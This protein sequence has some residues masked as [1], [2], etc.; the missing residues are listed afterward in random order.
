MGSKR[1]RD[2][3]DTFGSTHLSLPLK[4]PHMNLSYGRSLGIQ[5]PSYLCLSWSTCFACLLR[6]LQWI[7]SRSW[8]QHQKTIIRGPQTPKVRCPPCP[9][10]RRFN[11]SV[12]RTLP[13]APN[14]TC[15]TRS[16]STNSSLSTLHSLQVRHVWMMLHVPFSMRASISLLCSRMH[17][18]GL[19][20]Q[21][22]TCMDVFCKWDHFVDGAIHDD[23]AW[24][25]S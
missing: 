13:F 20:V 8:W 23:Q 9:T 12:N 17:Q 1:G 25:N 3:V 18:I 19:L 7:H 16:K 4:N 15:S 21:C 22:E 6:E 14:W 24:L 2:D 5:F 11:S 10:F